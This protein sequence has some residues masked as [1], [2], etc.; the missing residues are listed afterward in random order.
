LSRRKTLPS[1]SELH[2]AGK[3]RHGAG[4]REVITPVRILRWAGT[5]RIKV[6]QTEEVSAS[7]DTTRNGGID[8]LRGWAVLS[9]MLLHLNI[10]IPFV[11]SA[12]GRSL[13]KPVSRLLFW[14]GSWA[15]LV[16]FVISGFLITTMTEARWG[17]LTRVNLPAFYRIRFARIAPLLSLFVIVQSFLQSARVSGFSDPAP[18]A[19]LATTLF[20]VLT[21]R[22]NWL[23]AKVGYLPGAWDVLWS[24]SVEE[25]FYLGF[26]VLAR[27]ARPRFVLY[28]VLL[29]FAVAGPFA[30]VSKS[31][32]ELWQDHSYL[33]C[34]GEIAIG[35]LAASLA[36]RHAPSKIA[37]G[38]LLCA[39]GGLMLL[40]LYFRHAVKALRL[41]E[42]GLDVTV[43]SCGTSAVLIALSAMPTWARASN[44]L[45]FAP[46]R[47]LGRNS[48]EV[49]LSH[50][51]VILPASL[52]WQRLGSSFPIPLFYALVILVCAFLA[53]LI[54][55][56]FSKPLTQRLRPRQEA[57]S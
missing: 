4:L 53:E 37:A 43:L 8:V 45:A 13:P 39:G 5:G 46:L 50:L 41:Y 34:M 3:A 6:E 29:G 51:F 30:R 32:N 42:F 15:V 47:W 16:F 36:R 33:S 28:A 22:V 52:L 10:R 23:E 12:L 49:Y 18:T 48:Y 44:Q 56:G 20:S 40:V 19:S 21:F 38:V 17:A 7:R 27:V 25:L 24:L 35:C 31:S 26:P 14:S 9:V 54:A 55:R 2:D 1:V 11:G 57:S